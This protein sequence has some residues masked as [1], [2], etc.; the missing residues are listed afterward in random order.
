MKVGKFQFV[1]ENINKININYSIQSHGWLIL[2]HNKARVATYSLTHGS[3]SLNLLTFWVQ[4]II[5]NL[6]KSC[7][8]TLFDF[9]KL[10]FAANL[11]VY[12]NSY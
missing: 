1:P 5:D 6:T 4:F 11:I 8:I 10:L 9:K 12:F 3:F 7:R 2:M